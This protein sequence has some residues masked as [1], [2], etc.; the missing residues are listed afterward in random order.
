M[1]LFQSTSLLNIENDIILRNITEL[2][3]NDVI[4]LFIFVKHVFIQLLTDYVF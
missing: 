4:Q 3:L 1:T 2:M